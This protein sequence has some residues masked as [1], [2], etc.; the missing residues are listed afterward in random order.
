MA[1]LQKPNSTSFKKG[2]SG[3]P[4][5]LPK[6]PQAIA[7]QEARSQFLLATLSKMAASTRPELK[8]IIKDE[9]QPAINVIFA[10]V[11]VDATSGNNNARQVVLERLWG[12]P[13]EEIVVA[14]KT[15]LEQSMQDRPIEELIEIAR[16]A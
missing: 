8:A 12:K 9:S 4:S 7:I 6:D 11:V 1:G 2:K 5:G 14:T 3:N 16:G 10:R 15:T 13:K